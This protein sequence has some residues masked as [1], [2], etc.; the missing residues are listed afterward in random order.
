GPESDRDFFQFLDIRP[1]HGVYRYHRPLAV[2]GDIPRWSD[3]IPFGDGS[4]H[5]VR[6]Q[7][8]SFQALRVGPDDDGS[9]IASEGGRGR[10]AGETGE[11]GA[12]LEQGRVLDLADADVWVV[13]GTNQVADGHAAGVEAHDE[14]RD[15]AQRHERAGAVDVADGLGH[16]L[17][18]VG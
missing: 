18:H 12:D 11:H 1:D 9:L 4:D 6:G 5:L 2:D 15:G 10:H 17:G 8:V 13:G 3:H 14:G 16:R 7:V